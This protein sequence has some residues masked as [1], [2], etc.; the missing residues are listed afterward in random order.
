MLQIAETYEA[1]ARREAGIIGTD[2]DPS[3]RP[4]FVV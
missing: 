2:V 3:G 4:V 1:L